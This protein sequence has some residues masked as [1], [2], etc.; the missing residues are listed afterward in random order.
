MSSKSSSSRRATDRVPLS[1]T[2]RPRGPFSLQILV[3]LLAPLLALTCLLALRDDGIGRAAAAA[4]PQGPVST[5]TF[6]DV[7]SRDGTT[8]LSTAA[9]SACTPPVVRASGPVAPTS[10]ATCRFRV[11]T[12][13]SGSRRAAAIRHEIALRPERSDPLPRCDHYTVRI[14]EN[15]AGAVTG[16]TLDARTVPSA[17]WNW[18]VF[19]FFTD[20]GFWSNTWQV[21]K[22]T[23]SIIT[24]VVPI[25]KA[26]K[27]VKD[28]GGIREAAELLVKAGSWS[29]LRAVAP[30]LA[31][32]ILGI[33]LIENNCF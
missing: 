8:G 25:A 31:T 6:T 18:D 4:S 5:S 10:P 33:S 32:E 15:G 11:V 29:E 12:F 13:D 14:F 20:S 7:P 19:D 27:Y 1:L 9:R 2:P 21:T 23:A 22:C 28:L 17:R 16:C 30:G 3:F 24:A 26:G